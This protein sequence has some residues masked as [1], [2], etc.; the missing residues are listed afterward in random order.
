[1]VHQNECWHMHTYMHLQVQSLETMPTT[2]WAVE[3]YCS[4]IYTALDQ[5]RPCWTVTEICMVL[6][7]ALTVKMLELYVKVSDSTD[8]HLACLHIQGCYTENVLH[9]SS[10]YKW[11][12]PSHR[13]LCWHWKN[14]SMCYQ[15]MGHY[16]Q[17]LMGWCW[18]FGCLQPVRILTLWYNGLISE[19]PTV[20]VCMHCGLVSVLTIESHQEHLIM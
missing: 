14:W 19:W 17:Q 11:W 13:K 7:A 8:S 16:L 1:M 9:Y 6:W 4:L 18:C 2:E 12:C 20:W 5:R 3:Q 15:L 10:L